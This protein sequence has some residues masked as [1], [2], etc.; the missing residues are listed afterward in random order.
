MF[1]VTLFS[2]FTC[3]IYIY[4]FFFFCYYICLFSS[5]ILRFLCLTVRLSFSS[6]QT[7]LSDWFFF[8]A[9]NCKQLETLMIV[10]TWLRTWK[11]LNDPLLF[12]TISFSCIL[13][14]NVFLCVYFVVFCFVFVP[15][16]FLIKTHNSSVYRADISSRIKKLRQI[17][18]PSY[19]RS[20]E[21][22]I[23]AVSRNMCGD[24]YIFLNT[25]PFVSKSVTERGYEYTDGHIQLT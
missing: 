8:G 7:V 22:Y 10:G 14:T 24:I 1:N 25:I 12:R 20:E 3:L 19:F 2:V 16:F 23:Q 6:K 9:S 11:A 18:V 21:T 13:V 17:Q 5:C 15:D 4:M